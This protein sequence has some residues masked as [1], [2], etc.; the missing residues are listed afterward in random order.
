[1][2]M[3]TNSGTPPV[4]SA[5]AKIFHWLIF[6]LL[7]A[8]FVVALRMPHIGRGT[9]PEGMIAWHLSLGTAIIFVVVLRLIW[10]LTHPV[11]ALEASKWMG[12]AARLVHGLL[13]AVLIIMPVLGWANA[14]TRGFDV[15]LFGV[16]PLPR[17][18]PQGMKNG[19]LIGDVHTFMAYYVLLGLVGLHVIAALYHQFVLK[20]GILARMLPARSA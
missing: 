20:D 10:R 12:L 6:L 19:G 1:M 7:A 11:P 8:Q 9:K 15:T 18:L 13:Y 3:Q 14:S 16:I 2:N 5:V 17:L 4:Y